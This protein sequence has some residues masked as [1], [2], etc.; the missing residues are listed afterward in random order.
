MIQEESKITIE[1]S[2]ELKESMVGISAGNEAH[3]LSILRDKLYSD[4]ILAVVREYVTNAYDAHIENNIPD[5]PVEITIP[6]QFNP[7]FIVRDYGKGL[8]EQMIRETYVMYGASTKRT[9]NRVNGMYGIGSKAAFCYVD[10]FN[11][12]SIYNGV[13]YEYCCY[14]D[15]SKCGKIALLNESGTIEE[16]GIEIR[17]P[18]KEKDFSEFHN[19]VKNTFCYMNPLPLVN[20]KELEKIE[21]Q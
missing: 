11:I 9:T 20:G 21:V 7:M 3:I 16:S 2:H 8:D 19:K 17:I 6:N 18:V 4:K 14:I 1:K 5:R 15:E 12:T 10:S 13:K